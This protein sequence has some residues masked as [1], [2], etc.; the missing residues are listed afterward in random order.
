M[1]GIGEATEQRGSCRVTVTARSVNQRYLDCAVR[2]RAPYRLLEPEL[3]AV[4]A[5]EIRRG[6]VEL[7]VEIETAPDAATAELCDETADA[8]QRTVRRW[9]RRG[10][11]AS[12]LSAGEL[13]S[14]VRGSR[15]E[16]VSPVMGA[17]EREL[18]LRVSRR[19]VAALVAEREREG[20][21]L[22]D[23]LRGHLSEL[24]REVEAL[25]ARRGEVV[26]RAPDELERRVRELL[27]GD[28]PGGAAGAGLDPARLVQEVALLIERGDTAEE[29]ERLDGHL[30]GFE[31][32]MA[33]EGAVGRRLDFLTQEILR[34]LNTVGSKC[35]DLAM[36]RAVVEGKVLCEQLREQV[37]N[38]E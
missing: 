23:A 33:E 16:G 2:L 29:L 37:Q 28:E 25:A 14:A 35:R 4:I 7:R 36:Q 31:T 9:R 10:L 34:E 26:D 20:R 24:R 22:E 5:A 30:D 19:A 11:V 15:L 32:A 1:T 27:D 12:D 17:E 6:R 18:A 13:M 38:I 21:V 8:L 3:R